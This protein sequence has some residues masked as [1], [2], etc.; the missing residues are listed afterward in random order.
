MVFNKVLGIN[1]IDIIECIDIDLLHHWSIEITTQNATQKDKLQRMRIVA[2]KCRKPIET[3]EY[4]MQKKIKRALG[5]TAQLI[6]RR[7]SEVSKMVKDKNREESIRDDK[8]LIYIL[9]SL[10]APETW[11]EAL[12]KLNEWKH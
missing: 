9:K 8:K 10:I 4:R 12:F 11:E 1:E 7:I 6:S 3:D 5:R 2:R